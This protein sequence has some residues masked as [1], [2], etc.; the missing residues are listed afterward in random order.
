MSL[1]RTTKILKRVFTEKYYLRIQLL[2]R[3]APLFSDNTFLKLLFPM[4]VGYQLDLAN[5]RSFNEKLQ[6]LKLYY[7]PK[8]CVKMVDKLEVK[9][10]VASIIGEQHIIPTISVF[11]KAE[12]VDFNQLP[13]KF[14][15]K[16]THDSGGVVVCK[17]KYHLDKRAAISKLKK[18]LKRNYFY[19]NREWPY[20]YITPRIIAEQY[21]ED[22]SGEL[23][24]YK[25]FCFDGEPK[26]MF[27]ATDRFNRSEETKF[28]FY[29]MEFHHLPFTNGHPNSS[30]RLEKPKGFEEM[31]ELASELSQGFPH[32]RIDLYDIDG[33]V[34]FGEMT[35]FHWSGMK[36]FDPVEWDY[37]LGSMI[38]LPR[39]KHN[40]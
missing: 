19:Q 27:V 9:D 3:L 25:F 36:P 32:V 7:H 6:W 20:R 34:Y 4:K 15:L 40:M 28:D 29:D 33:E 2:A 18:G 12:D 21:M 16:C 22:E 24:D 5:P 17:D 1:G 8:Q 37:Y 23:R 11:E 35:F 14:V 30:K 38:H 10:L 26:V 13:E 31:K 39:I